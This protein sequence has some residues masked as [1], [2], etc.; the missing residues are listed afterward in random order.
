MKRKILN[1]LTEKGLLFSSIVTIT[2][3]IISFLGLQHYLTG[4]ASLLFAILV[5]GLFG[6]LFFILTDIIKSRLEFENKLIRIEHELRSTIGINK[7]TRLPLNLGGWAITGQFLQN[8]VEEI[9][10]REPQLIVE[11]GSGTSTIVSAACLKDIGKGKVLS[12]DHESYFAKKTRKLLAVEGTEEFAQVITAPI[13]DFEINGK[14]WKW[15]RTDFEKLINQQIDILVVD[16]PPSTLQSKSRYPAVPLLK[17]YLADDFLIMLDDGLRE[18]EAEIAK[19]WADILGVQA[20]LD[21]KNRG[22][23]K[24][25]KDVYES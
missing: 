20:T 13:N 1:N 8:L 22:F 14:T 15:Y 7:L 3:G 4:Q 2:T 6:L 24:I 11:C 5:G 16:G 23:W 17:K 21:N 19:E 12:L 9:Y 25:N 10:L 18:D